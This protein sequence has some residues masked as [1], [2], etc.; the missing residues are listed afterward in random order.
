MERPGPM[1]SLCRESTS[2]L[3][4]QDHD[5][6]ANQEISKALAAMREPPDRHGERLCEIAGREDCVSFCDAATWIPNLLW[7]AMSSPG[8]SLAIGDLRRESR[9]LR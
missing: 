4:P 1:G 9:T 3:N 5:P 6:K 7:L 2:S 8:H